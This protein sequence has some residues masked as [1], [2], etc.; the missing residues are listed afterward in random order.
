VSGEFWGGWTRA[1]LARLTVPRLAP[2]LGTSPPGLGRYEAVEA[3]YDVPSTRLGLGA[4]RA[5]RDRVALR[6]RA[7]LTLGRVDTRSF[8]IERIPGFEFAEEPT[9]H[10]ARAVDATLGAVVRL[11]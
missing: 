6:A 11:R 9:R 2:S 10:L 4:S 3:R 1:S 5:L 8:R 7:G